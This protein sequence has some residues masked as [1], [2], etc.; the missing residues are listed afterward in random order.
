MITVLLLEYIALFSL[1][2]CY[3][4]IL[5]FSVAYL[6]LYPCNIV[7]IGKVKRNLTLSQKNSSFKSRFCILKTF[8]YKHVASHDLSHVQKCSLLF[9]N[10]TFR[11]KCWLSCRI[12]SLTYQ[13]FIFRYPFSSSFSCLSIPFCSLRRS[14]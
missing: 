10:F 4:L 14:N 7:T 6:M 12:R 9:F 8:V 13:R 1:F 2:L 5:L 3:L 11:A